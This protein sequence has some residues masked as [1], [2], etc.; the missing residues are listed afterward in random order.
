[1]SLSEGRLRL[2]FRYGWLVWEANRR[3]GLTGAV[4]WRDLVDSHLVDSLV[5]ISLL[6]WQDVECIVDIGSGAGFP[7][8]VLAVVEPGVR[9]VLVEAVRKR[10]AFLEECVRYLGL[11]RAEVVAARAEE[12]GRRPEWRERAQGALARAVGPLAVVLEYAMPLLAVGGFLAAWKGPR[13]EEEMVKSQPALE[14]LRGRMVRQERYRLADGRERRLL[15]VQKVGVT[16][17]EY[18]RRVGVPAK[19]PLGGRLFRGRQEVS[20]DCGM[21]M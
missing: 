17:E 20:G 7:G 12:L 5:G 8:V 21:F 3:L 2:L 15:V 19:R 4:S 6:G 16:P 9:V 18:P 1:M 10:A 11:A 13:V 14:I